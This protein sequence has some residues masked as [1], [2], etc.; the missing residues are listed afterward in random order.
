MPASATSTAR[1]RSPGPSST[2]TSARAKS[3]GLGVATAVLVESLL[4][5]GS[6]A[7]VR[8]ARAAVA[9]LTAVP[10]EP[11]VVVLEIWLLRLR[12]LLAQAEGDEVMYYEQRD[13]YRKRTSELGF[14]GHISWAEAM[15]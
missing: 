8:E 3:C 10:T 12:A 7:D 13:R 4:Q 5:R 14:E 11:G 6:E 15:Q 1:S 2:T 9:K